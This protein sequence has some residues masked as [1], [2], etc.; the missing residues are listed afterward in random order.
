M[1]RRELKK[2]KSEKLHRYIREK[3]KLDYPV[4]DHCEN[5]KTLSGNHVVVSHSYGFF[6]DKLYLTN[7]FATLHQM[8]EDGFK[9][10][11]SPYSEYSEGTFSIGFEKKL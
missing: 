7:I 1:K 9:I 3:Y 8:V 2:S 6:D 10:T 4:L 11:F 5:F